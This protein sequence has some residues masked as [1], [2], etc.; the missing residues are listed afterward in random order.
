MHG[1]KIF[2]NLNTAFQD[3]CRR[4][5]KAF[6]SSFLFSSKR[7]SEHDFKSGAK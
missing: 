7:H 2:G 3:G 4:R 5:L 1:K 6:P